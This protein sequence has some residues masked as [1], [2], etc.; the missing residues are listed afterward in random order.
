MKQEEKHPN[1]QDTTS[2]TQETLT[3]QQEQ[4]NTDN[5]WNPMEY[6]S[7]RLKEEG[8]YKPGNKTGSSIMSAPKHS[9][10][11]R[12]QQDSQTQNE[13][14]EDLVDWLEKQLTKD[15][16]EL[17]FTLQTT[18]SQKQKTQENTPVSGTITFLKGD[19]AKKAM[20]FYQKKKEQNPTKQTQR[21][22]L[23]NSEIAKRLIED[24]QKTQEETKD[25]TPEELDRYFVKK[26]GLPL[27]YDPW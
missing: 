6:L 2:K 26:Y 10:S 5:S 3:M 9:Q 11:V 14:Q 13:K 24:L 7:K 22:S 25:M 15:M 27:E 18:P 1:Q 23:Q 12:Q 16:K 20:E 17:G 19:S 4:K 21:N 8:L